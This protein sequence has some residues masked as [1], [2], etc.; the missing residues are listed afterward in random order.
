MI[1]KMF[2]MIRKMFLMIRKRSFMIRKMF[3]MIRRKFFYEKNPRMKFRFLNIFFKRTC[4]M[5]ITVTTLWNMSMEYVHYSDYK[6]EYV[7]G[8]CPLQW[9]HFGICPGNMSITVTTLWQ[10]RDSTFGYS[11]N[12]SAILLSSPNISSFLTCLTPTP[13][14]T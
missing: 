10:N 3:F 12:T 5:S 14:F 4:N 8:I 6:L 13:W 7:Q 2:F 1:R 9:L 11:F